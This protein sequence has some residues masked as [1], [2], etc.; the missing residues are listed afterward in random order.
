MTTSTNLKPEQ[1]QELL[2]NCTP[3]PWSYFPKRKY[4]E[5][6]VSVPLGDGS[7]MSLGLFPDGV[8]TAHPEADG[9]LIALAPELAQGW[10]ALHAAV[11]TPEQAAEVEGLRAALSGCAGTHNPH[12]F[13]DPVLREAWARGMRQVHAYRDR[14]LEIQAD[15]ARG[16]PWHHIETGA[17]YVEV[18]RAQVQANTGALDEGDEVVVYLGADGQAHV[19]EADEFLERFTQ[20]AGWLHAESDVPAAPPE[21]ITPEEFIRRE[22]PNWAGVG[23]AVAWVRQLR[24]D[25]PDEEPSAAAAGA[26]ASGGAG[27]VRRNDTPERSYRQELVSADGQVY[28]SIEVEADAEGHPVPVGLTVHRGVLLEAYGEDEADVVLALSRAEARALAGGLEAAAG[29]STG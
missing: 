27:G 17:V 18:C 3:G 5:H 13:G 28:A 26:G 15:R 19:R 22:A 24:G 20:L 29:V 2:K 25:L 8:P 9:Q 11:P 12:V 10:V 4:N 1:V 7:Q 23:D 21:S 16:L 14:E 6:H